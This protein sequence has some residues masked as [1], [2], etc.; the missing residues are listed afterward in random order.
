M[1]LDL[2][3]PPVDILHMPT[4][5][6]GMCYIG[7]PPDWI[8]RPVAAAEI[9]MFAASDSPELRARQQAMINR[10]LRAMP[11]GALEIRSSAVV[12]ENARFAQGL[13]QI[14]DRFWLNGASGSRVRTQ[15][16]NSNPEPWRRDRYLGAF[17][18]S[19]AKGPARIPACDRKDGYKLDVAIELKNGFNYYHFSTETLGSLAHYLNDGTSSPITLHLP[20]SSVKGFMKRF[21]D[22]VF[23]S[24]ADRVRFEGQPEHYDRVRS[25][26]SHQHYLYAA[27]DDT[28]NV[29][30]NDPGLDPRWPE[31]ARDPHRIKR[32]AMMSYDTSL[33]LLRDAALSQI[34]PSAAMPRLVWMGRDEGGDARAR[35]IEGHEPLLE[36][37]SA[38]GFEQVAFEH[39]SPL[40][41]IA[42]MNGADIVIAPHGAGLANMIYAKPG[43]KIIEIGTRQT[44]LHRW[45]DFL[46]CAHVS[47]CRYDTVFADI[48]GVEDL[49]TV[50]KMSDGH[51]G[52]RVSRNATEH[53][54]SIVGETLAA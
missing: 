40:E 54:I 21:I 15:F 41:Q 12:L 49:T 45:G 20:T 42:T 50:P 34:R 16:E 35:G 51:R 27:S 18:R 31:I 25:V 47:R 5:H 33:R 44:Q 4:I 38:L 8:I 32:T 9:R 2:R 14:S 30:L 48:E 37:L 11:K 24:L 29:A 6:D 52:V 19:R 53:I 17:R 1:A 13:V 36:E 28:V 26:Y 46:K 3:R 10:Q 22:A 43:A 7:Q 23:P 39:L